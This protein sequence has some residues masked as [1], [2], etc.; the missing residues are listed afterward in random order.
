[1]Q[2]VIVF[3]YVYNVSFLFVPQTLKTYIADP[4][5]CSHTHTHT[6]T[7]AYCICLHVRRDWARLSV[8]TYCRTNI[9]R[10]KIIGRTKP[11]SLPPILPKTK[12]MDPERISAAVYFSSFWKSLTTTTTF[13]VFWN[14]HKIKLKL[15]LDDV[16]NICVSKS[17]S[18]K[19]RLNIR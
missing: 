5:L 8:K 6:Y 1:M 7:R 14:V 10:T 19:K 12:R 11:S 16:E 2:I 3:V 13:D 4:L 18:D 15:W 9:Q 17:V